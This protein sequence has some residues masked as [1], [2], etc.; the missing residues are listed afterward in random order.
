MMLTQEQKAVA[1]IRGFL[2][3]FG[4]GYGQDVRDR[5]ESAILAKP[6]PVYKPAGLTRLQRIKFRLLRMLA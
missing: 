3:G 2:A 5:V 6:E 1:R 4:F